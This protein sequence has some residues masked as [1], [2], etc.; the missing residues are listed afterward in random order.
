MHKSIKW[1]FA[2]LLGGFSLQAQVDT[3]SS[4]DDEFD[5]SEFELAAPAAKAYCNNKV[6]GQ[7]PTSLIGLFYTHQLSHDLILDSENSLDRKDRVTVNAAQQASFV[8]N[9]PLISRN[10]ILINMGITYQ[11]Q[12][13]SVDGVDKHPLGTL[14]NDQT[15]QRS[16]LTFTIFK[17]LNER[18]FIL[19]QLQAEINGDYSFSTIDFGKTRFPLAVLYGWKP[20]DR[21]MYAFGL[22][23]TYLGGALNYVPIAYYYHTFKNQKWGIEALLPARALLRYRF[24][25]ISYAGLGFNVNGAS[26]SLYNTPSIDYP[27]RPANEP[28]VFSVAD[29]ELRRA[30]ILAG[31]SYSR[32]LNGFF[33]MSVEAGYRLNYSYNVDSGGDFTRLFGSDEPYYYENDLQPAPY[34]T[35][36]LSYVSP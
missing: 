34:F 12:T 2:L 11:R 27:G 35:I 23:R 30:E 1:G 10:N 32:Q 16:N 29:Q 5:F 20:N 36:G 17:P 19:A 31:M 9:I 18:N 21:L 13:Y 6:L 33:W 3:T 26:Y 14:M 15:L 7:S 25:A 28:N 4:D 24:N 8:A 22:S